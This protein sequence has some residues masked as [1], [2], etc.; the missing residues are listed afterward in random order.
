MLSANNGVSSFEKYFFNRTYFYQEIEWEE[1]ART[2]EGYP[3]EEMLDIVTRLREELGDKFSALRDLQTRMQPLAAHEKLLSRYSAKRSLGEGTR[4]KIVHVEDQSGQSY[5]LKKGTMHQQLVSEKEQSGFLRG[6]SY[7]QEYQPKHI[8]EYTT[9]DNAVREIVKLYLGKFSIIN[10]L[11]LDKTITKKLQNVLQETSL[12]FDFLDAD[13]LTLKLWSSI[14]KNSRIKESLLK[15]SSQQR[16]VLQPMLI[17]YCSARLTAQAAERHLALYRASSQKWHQNPSIEKEIA[18]LEQNLKGMSQKRVEM[19]KQLAPFFKGDSSLKEILDYSFTH[20]ND[21]LFEDSEI[22]RLH[23]KIQ[24]ILIDELESKS[25]DQDQRSEA[26]SREIVNQYLQSLHLA[27]MQF[28]FLES[29]I[30][31]ENVQAFQADLKEHWCQ[32]MLIPGCSEF[33][34]GQVLD[35]PNLL[36]TKEFYYKSI[37]SA[38]NPYVKSYI[39]CEDVQGKSLNDLNMKEVSFV[40]KLI[41]LKQILSVFLYLDQQGLVYPCLP[42]ENIM[43]DENFKI[44]VID[45][46]CISLKQSNGNDLLEVGLGVLELNLDDP[47]KNLDLGTL[48]DLE[49]KQNKRQ[50]QDLLKAFGQIFQE[51]DPTKELEKLSRIVEDL[52]QILKP[53]SAEKDFSSVVQ[54]SL[55][56]V[57]GDPDSR[58]RPLTSLSVRDLTDSNK[59]FKSE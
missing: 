51:D 59:H 41:I 12:Q 47:C 38:T 7:F 15:L 11:D 45:L 57:A 37:E 29:L 4:G 8:T 18:Y 2:K 27:Q 19:G 48:P 21:L 1:E 9:S 52:I 30:E 22:Q 6:K 50:A 55:E 46:A 28:F 58:K 43:I 33:F 25:L 10:S 54:N 32:P 13:Q 24:D 35:H 53:A 34:M 20:L 31:K 36:K 23:Q 14:E 56:N 42:S 17:D 39:V 5:L 3:P 26:L 40:N 16:V 49:Q 44:T